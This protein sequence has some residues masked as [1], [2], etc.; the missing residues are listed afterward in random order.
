MRTSLIIH[1]EIPIEGQS[2]FQEKKSSSFF[3]LFKFSF[4]LSPLF[5]INTQI[6]IFA[7]PLSVKGAVSMFTFRSHFGPALRMVAI[8]THP[9][10]VIGL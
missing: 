9:I 10:R 2:L 8:S 7:D 3:L 6:T 1:N 5:V 4:V